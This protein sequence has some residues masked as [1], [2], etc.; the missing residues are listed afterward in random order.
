MTPMMIQY[1][2]IKE[3]HPDCLLFYRMGD[4]YELFFD[5]AIIAAK[6]LDI[7]LTKR[8]QHQ[9]DD[10][11]M[12]GVPFHAC[13]NY[14]AR[15]VKQGH[16]VAICEQTE[17]PAEA[18]KRGAKSVVKRE[19]VR[20]V[21]PGTL[22][23]ETLLEAKSH[24]FL[25][26]LFIAKN[27]NSFG[28]AIVDISTGHF[29]TEE[30]PL[31]SLAATLTRLSPS[32][33]IV[34]EKLLQSPDL[35]D[36]FGE[37]KKKLHPLPGS[38][39]DFSNAQKRLQEAYHVQ[40]L[41]GFA[42]FSD[43]EVTAAGTLLDYLSLT[44]KG[45][46]PRLMRP[47]K[48]ESSKYM[49][50]DAATQ[51][52]LELT[53]TLRGDRQG[54]LLSEIDCTLTPSGARL[55]TSDLLRPLTNISTLEKRLQRLD[56]FIARPET[57]ETL[58]AF[59][60]VTPDLERALSRLGLNRGGPRDLMSI[61]LALESAHQIGEELE[62]LQD[63]PSS[64][65]ST[66][67][68]VM[69]PLTQ[70][71]SSALSETLPMLA[72]EGDFIRE[73]YLPALDDLR[74][75]RDHGRQRILDLQTTYQRE[76]GVSSL[77]IKHNNVLGYYVDV[78][79][80]HKGKV[81]DRFIHR[82]TLVNSARFTTMDL[83]ELEQELSS[84]SEKALA[85]EL[86]LFDD[87]S[88]DIL[89]HFEDL[90]K[91]AH[92]LAR[93]DVTLALTH[94]A[95]K[96]HFCRPHIDASRTFNIVQGRHPVV[97]VFLQ[98]QEK[99]SFIPNDC[100]LSQD[101]DTWLLTGPNMAGK[102]TFLRQNA[103]IVLMAQMGSYVPAQSAHIGIVDALF[104]RVGASDDLARGQSTFM[105]EMVETAAIL[106][107]ATDRSFVILDEVGRGT[108]TYDGLSLA[109][110]CLEYLH[111]VIGCRTLFATHYHELTQLERSLDRLAC[112]SM[113]V[114]EWK[115]NVVF[116]H[117]VIKGAADRSYGIHVARLAGVPAAVS[118]RAEEI[119]EKLEKKSELTSQNQVV[120]LPLF[121]AMKEAPS[122]PKAFNSPTVKEEVKAEKD[123]PL[124]GLEEYF[125]NLDIDDLTPRQVLQKLYD[126]KDFLPNYNK[127]KK[128]N[129]PQDS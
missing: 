25:C 5:D 52:N 108:S 33:I 99:K 3:A 74:H 38:R 105:V 12:C 29:F 113:K 2:S 40:T 14:L 97:D 117:E 123:P 83:T 22:T 107:Q 75:V 6:A 118:H 62:S 73:G 124:S 35:F 47:Q 32:E 39:F 45:L 49:R 126:M 80:T 92:H 96:N 101:Q 72:R 102:S 26:A 79:N 100:S 94:I 60:K 81:D 114:R 98:R 103:L 82:Q 67:F 129:K 68:S 127:I 91:L 120:D 115:E 53:R 20:I 13:E 121:R 55:F 7:T 11:P 17:D 59:L 27:K 34:P 37:W 77:K 66:S 4:F 70:T 58:R 44:Q 50:L 95:H 56:Y 84:A 46:M 42:T 87:L 57:C 65:S 104:S 69:K 30:I 106:N 88:K 64:L 18:K 51:R 48:A 110:S 63:L 85:L 16:R 76:L 78:T 9:G 1:H 128:L 122:S 119:L 109:W 19:V 54:S 93:L 71:L 21:T 111:Q 116:L 41:D 61:K 31:L 23:E 24:N 89:A 10:I 8:G 15:L 43:S 36:V 125:K 28:I 112:Y 90:L 86:R